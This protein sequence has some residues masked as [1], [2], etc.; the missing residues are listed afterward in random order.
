MDTRQSGQHYGV[1]A[2]SEKVLKNA[3]RQRQ[4]ETLL[5]VYNMACDSVNTNG[6]K[7]Y[8]D[9]IKTYCGVKAETVDSLPPD[10]HYNHAAA[11]RQKDI[12]RAK[13][14]LK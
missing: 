11:P 4:L 6:M 12:D 8:R 7:A 10:L 9:L 5:K 14:W 2:F 13:A 1:I 3:D